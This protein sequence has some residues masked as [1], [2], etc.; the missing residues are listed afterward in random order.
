MKDEGAIDFMR[1]GVW[2]LQQQTRPTVQA[3]SAHF[4]VPAIEARRYMRLW[5]RAASDT[6]WDRRYW[7][8]LKSGRV[9]AALIDDDALTAPGQLQ[10]F[11][12][13]MEARGLRVERR[14][15]R[16]G[17]SPME[18]QSRR[19]EPV[20]AALAGVSATLRLAYG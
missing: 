15:Y 17:T 4:G 14:L 13:A 12:R 9:V 19:S 8:A 7:V 18:S 5:L 1:V 16:D 10:D 6:C 3:I 2:F 20:H 11:L